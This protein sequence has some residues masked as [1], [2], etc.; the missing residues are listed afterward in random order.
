M[1]KYLL[2]TS[3]RRSIS[4]LWILI[5]LVK[6]RRTFSYW[7]IILVSVRL[8]FSYR[9]ETWSILPTKKWKRR[10]NIRKYYDI[11][12]AVKIFIKRRQNAL[13]FSLPIVIW[14]SWISSIQLFSE[15]L[16]RVV[17]AWSLSQRN[18]GTG[19]GEVPTQDTI[20]HTL[21]HYGEFRDADQLVCG[22]KPE[23][24]EETRK[25]ESAP[26]DQR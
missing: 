14:K 17:E 22:K 25:W 12:K 4:L 13:S 16:H 24:Q 21:T 9:V 18:P 2:A 10:L 5:S 23:Y 19:L 20:T 26:D 8:M 3:A 1:R 6:F 15:L 7:G 11:I